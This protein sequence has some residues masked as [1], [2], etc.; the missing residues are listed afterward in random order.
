VFPKEE[1][2]SMKRPLTAGTQFKQS[3]NALID[4][5]MAKTPSYVR[6]I[7]PNH[8]KRAS[9]FDKAVVEHQ[10]YIVTVLFFFCLRFDW[11]K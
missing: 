11:H 4:T 5:L 10:V 2:D 3:L 9:M 6:C 7:K 1:L 8:E